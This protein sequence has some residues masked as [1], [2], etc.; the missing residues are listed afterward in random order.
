MPSKNQTKRT[1]VEVYPLSEETQQRSVSKE[2]DA[3]GLVAIL[4]ELDALME[5]MEN[6]CGDVEVVELCFNVDEIE[7]LGVEEDDDGRWI[8]KG[9]EAEK[10]EAAE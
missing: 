9:R 3:T 8:V 1:I 5:R 7:R 10:A 4:E 6:L 2:F